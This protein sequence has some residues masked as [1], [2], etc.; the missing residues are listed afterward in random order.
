MFLLTP[1]LLRISLKIDRSLQRSVIGQ[2]LIQKSD[3][4]LF[5][6]FLQKVLFGIAHP[7]LISSWSFLKFLANIRILYPQNC[8]V[9]THIYSSSPSP[10]VKNDTNP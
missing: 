2:N 9:F 8:E 3:L 10:N 1:P 5:P 7:S 4:N 6:T